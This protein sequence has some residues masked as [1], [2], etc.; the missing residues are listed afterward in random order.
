M[1]VFRTPYIFI[2][3]TALFILTFPAVPAQTAGPDNNVEWA[4]VSHV[5]F[6]DRRP[7]CPISNEAFTV[8]FQTYINDI[9][10]ARLFLDDGGST[11]WIIAAI[12]EQR[13]PY[14]IWEAQVPVTS[15]GGIGYYMELTDG[16]DI[17]YLSISGL[18]ETVPVDGLNFV[19]KVEG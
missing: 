17:D 19:E 3:I 1:P 7:L 14:D 12:L 11:S 16:T 15:A 18:T 13:G 10:G 8:R 5:D 4:G 6:Q 9:T 2:C